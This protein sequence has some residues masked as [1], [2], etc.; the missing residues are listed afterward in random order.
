[1]D[2]AAQDFLAAERWVLDDAAFAKFQPLYI[3]A[4]R[5]AASDLI[6]ASKGDNSESDWMRK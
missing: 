4:R 1:M 3:E 5:R 6:R 2:G